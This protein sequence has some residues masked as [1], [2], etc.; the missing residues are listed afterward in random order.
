RLPLG[1]L[2]QILERIGDAGA[3]I[4]GRLVDVLLDVGH[5]GFA[6]GLAELVLEL[7]RHAA[8]LAGPLADGAQHHRQILRLDEDEHG[9]R[10]QQQ[11]ARAEVEHGRFNS[12]GRLAT[13]GAR[14]FVACDPPSG[15][16]QPALWVSGCGAWVDGWSMVLPASCFGGSTLAVSSSDMPLLK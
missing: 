14:P 10:D 6:H 7:A 16:G 15:P 12:K 1:R 11:L 9:E 13:D 2:V 5:L 4:A 3:D 8:N